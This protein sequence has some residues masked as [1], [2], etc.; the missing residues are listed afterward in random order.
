MRIAA[1]LAGRQLHVMR[2]AILC[3]LL[4]AALA[5]APATATAQQGAPRRLHTYSIVARDSLT[6]EIGVAVQSHW[7]SV[8]SIV[9]WAEPGVGAVATQSFVLPAYGPRGLA[10]MRS[11]LGAPEAL[12]GLLA[13]DPDAPVRQVAM[14]DARGAVASHTGARNIPAAG[15]RT[16]AMYAVQANL[17]ARPTVWDAMARAYET[18]TGDLAERLLAALEAAQREGGD[19]RGQQSA[20]LIVVSGDARRPSWERVVDLRVEDS[21]EPLVELRRLLRVA[22]GYRLANQGDDYLTRGMVDSAL[23]A[24]GLADRILPDSAV[25]GELAYWV[26]VTLADRRRVDEA[27]PF[28]RRALAQDSAWATLL[29]RLPAVGL[30]SADSATI[31]RIVREASP[32]RGGRRR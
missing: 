5:A 30:L 3:R 29:W 14:V 6:G 7:F 25:N 28:F 24:Y 32:A 21:R 19:I 17:M 13:A 16:G 18:A 23:V 2:T 31:A 10:L 20:A 22:R 8:G 4:L 12:R 11:G 27:M 26:G 9:A 15:G 1:R